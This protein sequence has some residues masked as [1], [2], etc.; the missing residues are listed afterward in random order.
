MEEGFW[1]PLFFTRNTFNI[2]FYIRESKVTTL[3]SQLLFDHS[4]SPSLHILYVIYIASQEKRRNRICRYCSSSFVFICPSKTRV[5]VHSFHLS[6]RMYVV[7]RV[8]TPWLVFFS[9]LGKGVMKVV[10]RTLFSRISSLQLFRAKDVTEGEGLSRGK[11]PTECIWSRVFSFPTESGA[12]GWI[13]L[14]FLKMVI[15]LL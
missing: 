11:W 10:R 14:W 15:R 6:L 7:S 13:L 8:L 3:S 4:P 12:A 1:P 9:E 5:S 2:F